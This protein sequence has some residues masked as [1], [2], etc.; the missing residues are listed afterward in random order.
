MIL[1]H[2][3][4]PE[5]CRAR[6]GI[7][8]DKITSTT[9][10]WIGPYANQKPEDPRAWWISSGNDAAAHFIVKDDIVLAT[11]PMDEIAYH[12]GV[13]VGNYSSIG[14]EV[15]PAT[16]EGVF[17]DRSIETLKELLDKIPKV[18]LKRHYD[19]S[20]KDCPRY[21]TPVVD[22]G[23]ERWQALLKELGHDVC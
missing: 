10:H 4:L 13:P 22:G 16:N 7:K 17:S 6:P 3:Y 9:I 12:C 21:Y 14:I 18:P 19:W 15:I 11:I 5:G 20:K 1:I 23:E 8:F 2:N